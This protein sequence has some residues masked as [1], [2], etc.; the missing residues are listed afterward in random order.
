MEEDKKIIHQFEIE[1][2]IK[3]TKNENTKIIKNIIFII[4]FIII[5]GQLL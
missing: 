4:A 3:E 1:M 2:P 5:F